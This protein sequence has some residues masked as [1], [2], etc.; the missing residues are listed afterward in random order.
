MSDKDEREL[1][2]KHLI[3][4]FMNEQLSE[5][6]EDNLESNN[7]FVFLEKSTLNT[8]IIYMLMN[9]ERRPDEEA[10]NDSQVKILEELDHI[11]ADSKKGFEEIITLLKEI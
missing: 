6:K 8:L 10:F 3:R 5:R 2:M 11:I 9:G 1:F 4:Q 7:S